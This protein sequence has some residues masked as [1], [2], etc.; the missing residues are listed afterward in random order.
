[1]SPSSLRHAVRREEVQHVPEWPEQ[2]PARQ[3]QPVGAVPRPQ[4][5]VEPAARGPVLDQLHRTDEPE[6]ADLAHEVES[7]ER[8]ACEPRQRRGRRNPLEDALLPEDGQVLEGSRAGD[9]VPGVA[10]AV[11]ERL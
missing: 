10:V 9:R 8:L 1:M 2:N 5:P 7:R 11:H 6:L 3:R 4:P